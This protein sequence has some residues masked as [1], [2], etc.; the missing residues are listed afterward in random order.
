MCVCFC[1]ELMQK[2]DRVGAREGNGD[3]DSF[4]GLDRAA[5]SRAHALRGSVLCGVALEQTAT[6]L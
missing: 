5:S 6:R 3:S 1:S 4:V 2:S